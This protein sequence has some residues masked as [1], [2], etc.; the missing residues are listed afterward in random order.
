MQSSEAVGFL[1]KPVEDLYGRYVGAV[2]G[3]SLKTNGEVE[4]VGV[5]QGSGSFTE[6]KA[7]RL[8][9]HDQAL[10]VVP[11]WKAD[12]MRITGETG[13]LDKR[14]SALHE[15]AKDPK[16]VGPEALAQYDQL[17]SQYE[18][19]LAKIQ[20]SSEKLFQEMSSRTEDLDRADQA[21]A[22]FLV[23]VNIQF[24]SGE[25][26]EASFQVI[27]EQ[28]ETMKAR[29]AKEREEL[30]TAYGMLGRKEA[31]R[32]IEMKIPVSG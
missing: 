30:A 11:V 24:R 9:L 6:V 8:V 15:L 32:P 13:V 19:R 7:T 1:G 2:I 5:D 25:I 31:V 21:M 22:K 26:S 17:R 27:I 12:V 20:E 28:F 14:I 10:I 3:F 4:S 23:N 29:N 18:M 16:D